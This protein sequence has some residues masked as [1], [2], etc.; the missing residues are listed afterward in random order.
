MITSHAHSTSHLLTGAYRPVTDEVTVHDLPVEGQLP[1][2]LDGRFLRVGP[3]P[4]GRHDPNVDHS[5]AGDAMVHALR[6]R[7]GRAQW[8]RNRW[9]RTDQV[10]AAFGELPTPGPRFGLSDNANAGLVQHAGRLLAVADGGVLPHQIGP[11]AGD[12]RP[13][14]LRRHAARRVLRPAGRRPA[15]RR[16]ARDRVLP[17]AAARHLPHRSTSSGGCARPSPSRSRAPR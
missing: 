8:Y 17:R 15:H 12:G 13:D 6:L 4:L 11:R 5:L 10:T 9:L 16:A 3:N 7:D 1:A 2:E 14:R